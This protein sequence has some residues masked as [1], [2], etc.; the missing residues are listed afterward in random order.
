MSIFLQLAGK[1]SSKTPSDVAAVRRFYARPTVEQLLEEMKNKN[2][3]SFIIAR[4]PIERLGN[5]RNLFIKNTYTVVADK[6]DHVISQ[7]T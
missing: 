5:F 4:N 3:T 2:S 6:W 1:N 7:R